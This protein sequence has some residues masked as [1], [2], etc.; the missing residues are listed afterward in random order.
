MPRIEIVTETEGTNCWSYHVRV[1]S[2][3][4]DHDFH[5]SLSWAD[6]D[7]WCHGRVAPQ[8]V[9]HAAFE[10]LLD[11]EE[12]TAILPRFDCALIRRYFPEIDR[13]LPM[14]VSSRP[15]PEGQDVGETE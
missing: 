6:Y 2:G 14:M 9:V 12:V 5:V 3:A 15:G 10:F 4:A 8:N 11:R 13:Q 7:L 1:G